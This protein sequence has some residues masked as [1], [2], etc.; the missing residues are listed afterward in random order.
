MSP[1][2]FLVQPQD[3]DEING[4]LD[5]VLALLERWDR[6]RQEAKSVTVPIRTTADAGGQADLVGLSAAPKDRPSPCDVGEE[7]L[8]SLREC[9]PCV[10][11]TF[12]PIAGS[13]SRCFNCSAGMFAPRAG[14]AAC[15]PCDAGSLCGQPWKVLFPGMCVFSRS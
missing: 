10:P 3:L 7:Y 2:N 12:S 6:E 5:T 11:G 4:K 1:V 9:A 14:S 13:S 15:R 8:V